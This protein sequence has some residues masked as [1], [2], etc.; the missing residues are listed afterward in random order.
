MANSSKP[1]A[2]DI[3]GRSGFK[4]AS[5]LSGHKNIMHR[6]GEQLEK[7]TQ[8]VETITTLRSDVQAIEKRL[9]GMETR[10][11]GL[12]MGPALKQ[13]QASLSSEIRLAPGQSDMQAI[14]KRLAQIESR[15]S[16]LD[17]RPAP[18]QLQVSLS[19]E[20]KIAPGKSDDRA[21]VT[22]GREKKKEAAFPRESVKKGPSLLPKGSVH[23]A[24]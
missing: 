20:I 10:L 3:C 18:K 5:G 8:A 22:G 17:M 1:L 16:G 9:V 7:L 15:L 11:S 21:R 14:E 23:T 2:C 24:R 4:N 6:Q 13:L 12:D 19:P